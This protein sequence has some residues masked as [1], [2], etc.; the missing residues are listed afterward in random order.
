MKKA[1]MLIAVSAVGLGTMNAWAVDNRIMS[2]VDCHQIGTNGTPSLDWFGGIENTNVSSNMQV[3]CPIVRDNDTA[4]PFYMQV[5]VLDQDPGALST[6]DVGC[7][8]VSTDSP[9]GS[10][11]T[12]VYWGPWHTSSGSNPAYQQLA[13]NGNANT[14]WMGSE[15]VACAIPKSAGFGNSAI[16]SYYIQE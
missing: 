13:F 16:I 7:Q 14:F 11:T 3:L 1:L 2:A 4:S 6:D 9:A 15:G 12:A 5:T 10:T 8:I